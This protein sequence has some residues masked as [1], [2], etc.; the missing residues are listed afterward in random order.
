MSQ[1]LSDSDQSSALCPGLR[2]RTFY[3][4]LIYRR[5]LAPVPPVFTCVTVGFR[6]LHPFRLPVVPACAFP[7]LAALPACAFRTSTLL[8][9]K[10][11][12]VSRPS[13]VCTA[14]GLRALRGFRLLGVYLQGSRFPFESLRWLR[15]VAS[16]TDPG[17]MLRTMRALLPAILHPPLCLPAGRPSGRWVSSHG[18]IRLPL[19]I[20]ACQTRIA[21]SYDVQL[22]LDFTSDGQAHESNEIVAQD[23]PVKFATKRISPSA[24]R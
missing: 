16:E 2:S 22:S 11:F 12:P 7:T 18:K 5:P 21:F 8:R 6:G 19:R 3:V 9:P 24:K 13:A 4:R 14:S 15:S 23:A 17:D 1:G 10:S 20:R